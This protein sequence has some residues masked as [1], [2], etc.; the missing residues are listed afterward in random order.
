MKLKTNKNKQPRTIAVLNPAPTTRGGAPVISRGFTLIELLVVIA[1]IAILAAMLLPALSKAKQ[2][3]QQVRCL[4]NVKQITL[5][6]KS[7]TLD[8]GNVALGPNATLWMG[9]LRS[10]FANAKDVLRCPVTINEPTSTGPADSDGTADTPWRIGAPA[11]NPDDVFVGSYG[12]NNWLYGASVGANF[13]WAEWDPSKAFG[14]DTSILS[15]ATTPNFMDCVRYGANPLASS[16]PARNLYN[17]QNTPTIGRITIARHNFSSPS[18]AP[19][20]LAPGAPLPGA[21]NMG[22]ADGHASVVKL[23]SLWGYTWHVGY[24]PPLNR[25]R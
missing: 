9:A 7:Y 4:S 24:V 21:I 3:A 6:S 8:N 25:P 19:R 10:S 22:F 15:P 18:A 23:E 2:K 5:A 20:S 13:G 11:T 16:T 14:K 12:I 17:G 1:I